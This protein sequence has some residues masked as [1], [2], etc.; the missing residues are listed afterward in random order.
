MLFRPLLL[1]IYTSFLF[2]SLT[3]ASPS[4][5]EEAPVSQRVNGLAP[6]HGLYDDDK[7]EDHYI[8]LFEADHSLD[9]H[10][11]HLGQDLSRA[12]SFI[13]LRYGYGAHVPDASLLMR[14]RSDAG[15]TAVEVDRVVGMA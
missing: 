14:I 4:N 12:E 6:L 8:V 15:V 3:S 10:Y 11:A 7:I 13:K 2:L 9:D 1:P 5:K